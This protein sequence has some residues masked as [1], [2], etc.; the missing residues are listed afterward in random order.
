[1]GAPQEDSENSN[2]VSTTIKKNDWNEKIIL[3]L[4]H[5]LSKTWSQVTLKSWFQTELSH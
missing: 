4:P 1:M 5:Q 3:P 2:F